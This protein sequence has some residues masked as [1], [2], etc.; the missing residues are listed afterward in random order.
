MPEFAI[1]VMTLDT[2]VNRRS[3]V[4]VVPKWQLLLPKD[5]HHASAL[6]QWQRT[7]FE[8]SLE[9]TTTIMLTLSP[10][11]HIKIILNVSL[12]TYLP[13]IVK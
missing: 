12:L 1:R 2:H 8:K 6:H 7:S 10:K 9:K 5:E 11:R 4:T 13:R 3:S